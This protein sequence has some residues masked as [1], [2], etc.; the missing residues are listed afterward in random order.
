MHVLTESAQTRARHSTL[1]DLF[2]HHASKGG[3]VCVLELATVVGEETL[4]HEL[5]QD[6]VVS[7]EGD[8][9]IHVSTQCCQSVLCQEA[10]PATC[11]TG[12]LQRVKRM[13]GGQRLEGCCQ[14]LKVLTV[15]IGV[16]CTAKDRIELLKKNFLRE[17]LGIGGRNEWDEAALVA[18][19]IH[20][21]CFTLA[22]LAKLTSLV[23]VGHGNLERELGG[24]DGCTV[25]RDAAL[26][27]RAQHREETAA[28]AGNGRGVR[29]IFSNV[30]VAVE[31]V[32]AWDA[33]MVKVKTP[34][35][36]SVQSALETVVFASNS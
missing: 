24:I 36:D 27:E 20:Q 7:F 6:V 22:C 25:Q 18:L 23:A 17:R 5:E 21:Y 34:V 1:S 13:P 11:F 14:C 19:V 9:D 2:H 33:D 30:A 4:S 10:L 32:S 3:G 28:W 12:F 35:I 8:I 31:Q 26:H 15:V 16:V 29:S